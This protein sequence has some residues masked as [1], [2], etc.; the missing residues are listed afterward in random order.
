MPVN[1]TAAGGEKPRRGLLSRS[2]ISDRTPAGKDGAA[3]WGECSC[4][5]AHLCRP[6]L[7]QNLRMAESA[8][9]W[10]SVQ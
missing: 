8:G 9:H 3:R 5:R 7:R 6:A 2:Y 10:T 1:C 4:A